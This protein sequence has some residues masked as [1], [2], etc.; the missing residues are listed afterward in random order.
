MSLKRICVSS[1]VLV[2]LLV[3]TVCAQQ[4]SKPQKKRPSLE[5]EDIIPTTVKP[6]APEA[7]PETK[8]DAKP[9]AKGDGKAAGKEGEKSEAKGD[10]K[11]DDKQAGEAGQNGE[12]AD[13][14]KDDPAE[15]E[16]RERMAA[17]RERVR[18]LRQL[19]Q[20]TELQLT[21][22]RNNRYT[23]NMTTDKLNAV[24]AALDQNGQQLSSLRREL[25]VA[26]QE[27]EQLAEEGRIKKFHET[28]KR[29]TN[30]KGEA[31]E[32]YYKARYVE[33]VDQVN[34]ADRRVKLLDYRLAELQAQLRGNGGASGNGKK[35][36]G[37]QFAGM[38][39]QQNIDQAMIDM[40]LARTDLSKAQQALES[41]MEEARRAGLPPGIFRQ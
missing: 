37:D 31:N 19:T 29:P 38:R 17:A 11:G 27:L 24:A 33:L 22:I 1:V 23:D 12:K 30:E 13:A 35:G 25:N 26:S 7:K 34:D 10:G 28:M 5:T 14:P 40:D 16:W 18:Q 3:A 9:D 2:F 15:L 41:L 6:P 4:D 39:I 32:D 20:Q 21:A 8:E 36:G